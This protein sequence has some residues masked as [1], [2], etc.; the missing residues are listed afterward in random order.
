MLRR[1]WKRFTMLWSGVGAR[2]ASDRRLLDD[3]RGLRE[4]LPERIEDLVQSDV[5]LEALAER[6][7]AKLRPP[8]YVPPPLEE[9]QAS[10][11]R[12]SELREWTRAIAE[13]LRSPDPAVTAAA[14]ERQRAGVRA[15]RRDLGLPE[16]DPQ[17][18]GDRPSRTEPEPAAPLRAQEQ[19]WLVPGP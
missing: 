10:V 7:A 6:V 19:R 11:R 16:E 12:L 2:D 14:A 1:L 18:P 17:P 9:L 15:L 5:Y 8:P 4:H 13:D 3:V